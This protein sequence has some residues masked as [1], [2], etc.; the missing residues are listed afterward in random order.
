MFERIVH[1]AIE[2]TLQHVKQDVHE[3]RLDGARVHST[4]VTK[5]VDRAAG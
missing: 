4:L 1:A 5:V 2:N 3:A